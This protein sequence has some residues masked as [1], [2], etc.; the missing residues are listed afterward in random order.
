[1]SP[2][3]APAWQII[4]CFEWLTLHCQCLIHIKDSTNCLPLAVVVCSNPFREHVSP[5]LSVSLGLC[6]AP[7]AP[8]TL[9]QQHADVLAVV[10][11]GTVEEDSLY[12]VHTSTWMTEFPGEADT[13]SQP[14]P[15]TVTAGSD[16]QQHL[17]D[18][19]P[20][21][22]P[23]LDVRELEQRMTPRR[24]SPEDFA[25]SLSTHHG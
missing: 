1:M 15:Y 22:E 5:C 3:L 18:S 8:M 10:F 12:P 6:L 4:G 25:S 20:I 7:S 21:P 11:T 16:G 19:I 9:P 24:F 2:F 23:S 13:L 17:R 14:S